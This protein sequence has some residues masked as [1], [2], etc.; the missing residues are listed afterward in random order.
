MYVVFLFQSEFLCIQFYVFLCAHVKKLFQFSIVILLSFLLC[1]HFSHDQDA[2]HDVQTGHIVQC[3][4]ELLL[5]YFRDQTYWHPQPS[6]TS[7][8]SGK[9]CQI[10]EFF[11][12]L[13][14][15]ESILDVTHFENFGF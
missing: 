11:L 1:L 13:H 3:L 5:E 12:Q 14:M 2:I 10:S 9:C 15:P 6:V 7:K 8:W 4:Y